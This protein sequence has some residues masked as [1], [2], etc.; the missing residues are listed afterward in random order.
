MTPLRTNRAKEIRATLIRAAEI[1]L[2]PWHSTERD[3]PVNAIWLATGYPNCAV[4]YDVVLSSYD[5]SVE[6]SYYDRQRNCWAL[7]FAAAAVE[8]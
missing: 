4:P 2:D 5:E 8:D 6:R 3:G 1:A 7:L